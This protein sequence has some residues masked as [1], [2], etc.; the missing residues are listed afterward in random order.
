MTRFFP[1]PPVFPS[2]AAMQSFFQS[3]FCC[4]QGD[5]IVSIS[6]LNTFNTFQLIVADNAGEKLNSFIPYIKKS[7]LSFG[8][9]FDGIGNV[10]VSS[11]WTTVGINANPV[12]LLNLVET[13]VTIP[14]G[15]ITLP[16]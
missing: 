4:K 3:R 14:V 1:A 13:V 6:F 11:N 16:V 7:L 10:S 8:M 5:A 12:P 15:P 2:T 9:V